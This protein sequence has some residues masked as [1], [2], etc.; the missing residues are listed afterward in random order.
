MINKM[1][2]MKSILVKD[3]NK[4]RNLTPDELDIM[5]TTFEKKYS[6]LYENEDNVIGYEDARDIFDDFFEEYPEVVRA[7]SRHRED[8]LV[9]DRERAAFMFT[10][11]DFGYL[12]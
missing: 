3:F 4:K 11:M 5:L 8:A 7:F 2:R 6:Y 9:S 10:V 1:K 12:D